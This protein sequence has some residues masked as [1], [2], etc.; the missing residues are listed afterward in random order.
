MFLLAPYG[1]QTTFN[2]PMII[3]GLV[4]L[5][6]QADWTP[7]PGD[8]RISKNGAA[9]AQSTNL[10][11]CLT[12]PD[13]HWTLTLTAAELTAAE[14]IVQIVDLT[15]PKAVEDQFILI[16]TYGN[17][18]AKIPFDF[19]AAATPANITQVLGTPLVINGI[20]GQK[21]GT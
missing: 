2:H 8:I 10:S 1:V 5:A 9:S 13:V 21:I 16:Y 15:N 18:L 17:A 12:L 7:A 14:I 3:R 11:S 19:S 20:G 4:D 6:G